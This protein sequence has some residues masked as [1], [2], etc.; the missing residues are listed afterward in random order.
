[1]KC[2]GNI[3][4][5]TGLTLRQVPLQV[6][7]APPHRHDPPARQAAAHATSHDCLLLF[8][9]KLAY[10]REV[11][12]QREQAELMQGKKERDAYVAAVH[13]VLPPPPR[14]P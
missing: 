1:M 2:I 6:Q 9:E 7:V 13:K 4:N 14:P 12:R 8:T 5:G 3:S 10:D 11:Q